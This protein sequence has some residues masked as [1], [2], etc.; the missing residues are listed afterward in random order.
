MCLLRIAVQAKGRL[1]EETMAL[2][3]ESDIKLSTTKR[4]LLVQSSNFPVEVLFLRDDDIPQSVAT[5]VADLG[6]VGEN[7]FVEKGEDAE[8]IKRLGFSK[9]RLSLAMPKDVD[10][11]GVEWF[12][13]K[14]IATSYPV[15]LEN[16]MK[17]KGVN[18]EV[19]VITG[20]V[21]V[22]PGIGLADAIFD[23][24]SSGSTLVS[25][26]LKEV[27]VV[28]KSE[29]LL[30]GNKNMCDEKKEILNELLFRMNAVKTAED[31]KYVLMNAP[32][33]KLEEIVAVLP[34]MK[35][36]TVM[37]LAQEGWCSVHT[38][39]DEKRFWEIIGKLKALG[40]EGILVLPI[41]KMIL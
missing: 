33:D 29:A 32:K 5:G 16:Y 2:L 35:S 17:T 13:G 41:E 9:C 19:H 18:A 24:V 36:P 22:A 39:L 34:G 12:N 20:S 10:Y 28:M 23:I 14:K 1:F 21:E 7:E 25:N 37:P 15:I 38:V 40:A 11:P 30:I 4:T 31:K 8:V 3:E 27:E 6:I 26:R